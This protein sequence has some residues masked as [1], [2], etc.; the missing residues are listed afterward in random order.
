[1]PASL[2]QAVEREGIRLGRT[3]DGEVRYTSSDI[4]VVRTALRLL[5]FGLPLPDLLGLARDADVAMRGLAERAV[6][7]F[8]EHVRK[9]IRDTAGDDEAAS[10]QM[11][12][13]FGELLPA[14]TPLVSHHFR[15]VL[16]ETAEEH[17]EE[18]S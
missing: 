11:V 8:D 12:E 5:E 1:M 3:V 7:L 6:D 13:A 16:L 15:R 10:A 17:I 14:V 2:I 4:E 9:P 18:T